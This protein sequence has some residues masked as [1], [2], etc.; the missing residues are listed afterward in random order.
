MDMQTTKAKGKFFTVVRDGAPVVH[1]TRKYLTRR[2]AEAAA[3]C[4]WAFHGGDKIMTTY[5]LALTPM[6]EGGKRDIP[7]EYATKADAWLA[8]QQTEFNEAVTVFEDG[9]AVG[10]FQWMFK[11]PDEPVP[12]K[13]GYVRRVRDLCKWTRKGWE[14][15]GVQA[16]GIGTHRF[17]RTVAV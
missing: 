11:T 10:I 14:V 2:M 9:K 12:G 1:I 17:I 16:V 5:T 3:K 15:T 8:V 13:P 6:V 4:W 7:G